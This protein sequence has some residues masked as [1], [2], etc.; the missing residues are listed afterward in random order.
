VTKEDD[1][2]LR[3]GRILEGTSVKSCVQCGR[4]TATC[5]ASLPTDL[6]AREVIR[7]RGRSSGLSRMGTCP[8]SPE[9][10]IY[11]TAPPAS[12]ARSVAPRGSW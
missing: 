9:G 2:G 5:P 7:A 8:L 6:R 10:T 4:C 11:G 12:A 1:L 3:V